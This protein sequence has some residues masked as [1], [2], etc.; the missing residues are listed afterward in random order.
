MM[1]ISI[2]PTT[3]NKSQTQR[4]KSSTLWDPDPGPPSISGLTHYQYWHSWAIPKA[5]TLNQGQP[6]KLVCLGLGKQALYQF[7]PSSTLDRSMG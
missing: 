7:L 6:E 5:R 2:H 4:K 1:S 3:F